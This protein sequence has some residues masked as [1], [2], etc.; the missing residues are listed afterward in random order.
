MDE[1]GRL[2]WQC[3][4]GMLELDLLLRRFVDTGYTDLGGEERN[5]FARLLDYPDDTLLELLMGRM[6]S[7]EGEITRV[8]EKIRAA[9][10]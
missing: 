9:Q 8:I 4:R 6:T 1:L 10:R 7:T 2:R 3:R 5:A